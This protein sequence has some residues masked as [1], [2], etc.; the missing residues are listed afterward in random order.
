MEPV[1]LGRSGLRVSP[2]CLGTMTF[3]A[4]TA[5]AEA[6]DIAD[7]CF[8]RG[9]FFWDTA[10]M[11]SSGA[12][13]EMVGQLM[14]GRRD[15]IVLATKAFAPMGPGPNDRGLSARHLLAACE[16]S[17]RRLRTDHIDL[18]Y[19]HLP[20]RSVPIEE[21]LRALEDLIRA[22]K[23]RY[24]ACSNYRAWEVVKLQACARA[25]GWQPLTAVQ[26]LYN[27]VNRDIEVELLPMAADQGLGVVSYSPLARGVLTGK[28]RWDGPTPEAS[29]LAR[30]DRRFLQA[31][32]REA[33]VQVAAGLAELA[34]ARGVAAATLAVRW[35]MA[36]ELVH[37]VIVGPRTVAHAKDYLA[38]VDLPWDEELEAACDALVP[39]GSHTGQGWPDPAYYPVTGRQVAVR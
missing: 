28:Y 35:A 7:R 9:I 18:Y 38:A 26:P 30:S 11:Y 21:S 25:H 14:Q 6:R 39:P 29:R 31:E 2:L 20:D 4:T 5:L 24:A 22:G 37:S 10:D 8:D 3:A 1:L 16:A 15:Q 12:S 13:E 17:L 27:L 23:V 34:E 36:N 32:W 33:S 19:L